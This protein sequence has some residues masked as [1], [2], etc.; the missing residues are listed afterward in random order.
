MRIIDKDHY[1]LQY[2]K[3]KGDDEITKPTSK[4]I[5]GFK[6]NRRHVVSGLAIHRHVSD[7]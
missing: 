1:Q 3:M 2:N 5:D 6:Y 7:A 4:K